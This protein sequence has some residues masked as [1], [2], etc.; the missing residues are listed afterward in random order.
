MPLATDVLL[1]TLQMCQ[2]HCSPKMQRQLAMMMIKHFGE[3]MLQVLRRTSYASMPSSIPLPTNSS[4][5]YAFACQVRR[6][7]CI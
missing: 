7:H 3:E 5:V 4:F 1:Q 6:L 2:M